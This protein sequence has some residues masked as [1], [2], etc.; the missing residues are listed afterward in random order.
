MLF[1][2]IFRNNL[3]IK[4]QVQFSDQRYLATEQIYYTSIYL[5][6]DHVTLR[7]LYKLFIKSQYSTVL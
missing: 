7:C 5:G 4:S 6:Q 2:Y 3:I 1:I